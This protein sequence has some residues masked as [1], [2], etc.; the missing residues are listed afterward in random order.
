MFHLACSRK[1]ESPRSCMAILQ[2]ILETLTRLLLVLV[3]FQSPFFCSEGLLVLEVQCESPRMRTI[4][5]NKRCSFHIAGRSISKK[6][7]YEFIRRLVRTFLPI[8]EVVEVMRV[9]HYI[10]AAGEGQTLKEEEKS[11]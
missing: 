7:S 11:S 8:W 4:L 5:R 1:G 6:K 3:S 9:V 10:E 2:A